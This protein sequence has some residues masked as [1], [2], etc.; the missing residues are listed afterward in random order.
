[1]Q[2]SEAVFKDHP[3]NKQR[4]ARGQLRPPDLVIL[5]QRADA[6]FN[7]LSRA[8]RTAGGSYHR[9]RPVARTGN[10]S[11]NVYFANPRRHDGRMNNYTAQ[12]IGGLEALRDYDIV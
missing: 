9:C 5:G 3:V 6:G 4:I 12:A 10:D 2:R 8:L 1:M 7:S 11:R